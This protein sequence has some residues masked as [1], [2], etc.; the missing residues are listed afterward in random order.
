MTDA[1]DYPPRDGDYARAAGEEAKLMPIAVHTLHL[2][3]F[4]T[5][6]T[7]IVAVI[8]AYLGRRA[9][10]DWRTSHYEFGIWTF[11]LALAGSGVGWALIIVGIPLLIAFGLGIIPIVIGGAVLA[12]I[13]IWFA[14]R[15]V[16]GL[17]YALRGEAYPRPRALLA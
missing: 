5:G 14:V 6:F 1:P 9:P 12:L 10:E 13:G 15:A 17:V 8:V 7:P 2:L 11:W 4:A 3:F 16:L